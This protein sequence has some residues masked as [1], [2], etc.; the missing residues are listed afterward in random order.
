MLKSSGERGHLCLIP[1][2]WWEIFKFLTI[3]YNVSCSFFVDIYIFYQVE[4]VFLCSEFTTLLYRPSYQVY[5]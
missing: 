1:D 5:V 4:E 2:F 3:K